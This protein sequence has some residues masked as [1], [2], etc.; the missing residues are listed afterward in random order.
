MGLQNY[1]GDGLVVNMK[2][3]LQR[4]SLSGLFVMIIAAGGCNM[5]A[6]L[7]QGVIGEGQAVLVTAAYR[8]LQYR[9]VAVLVSSADAIEVRYPQ[10][11]SGVC[12]MIS[13]T[14]ARDVPGVQVINADKAIAYTQAHRGW[15]LMP[16]SS[17]A[18]QLKVE[19][20]VLIDMHEYRTHEPGNTNVWRGMIKATVDVTEVDG[21][22]PN[23][24]A[25][26]AEIMNKY[27]PTGMV[28]MINSDS[29]SIEQQMLP[30]FAVKVMQLFVDHEEKR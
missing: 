29:R 14:I 20:L 22:D 19:R 27:P 13:G 10:A 12:Q 23:T 11:A 2:G 6:W 8:G 7:G 17:I 24:S 30:G 28:G 9:S 18:K 1:Y 5:L 3:K 4:A 25:F 15:E 26:R 21:A 16:A